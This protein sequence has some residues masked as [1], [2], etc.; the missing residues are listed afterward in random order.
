MVSQKKQ[1]YGGPLTRAGIIGEL[2]Y[3]M[4]KRKLWWLI[5]MILVLVLFG[6][7]LIFFQGSAIGPFIYTLF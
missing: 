2:M 3:F 4:W 7:L 1:K 5:P 6:A